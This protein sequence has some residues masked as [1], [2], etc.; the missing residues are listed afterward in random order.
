M[1]A[2]LVKEFYPQFEVT[3]VESDEIGILGAGEGTV[4]HIVAVLDFLRIP[5]SALVRE[6]SATLKT[7]IRFTNWHGDGTSYFHSFTGD[8]ELEMWS[9]DHIFRVNLLPTVLIGKA[10][11]LDSASFVA[12]IAQQGRVPFILGD[13][14]AEQRKNFPDPLN[15]LHHIGSFALHFDARLLAKYLG[16]LAQYER[17]I[18]R[19]QGKL[20]KVLSNADGSIAGL[21]L[22]D[23]TSLACDFIFDCSGFARLLLGKHFNETWVDYSSYLPLDTALP[24]FLPHDGTKLPPY[25]EAIAMKYGWIWKIPVQDRYGCGYVFDS[26]FINEAQALAEVEDWLGHP[27]T[28]PKTF[29]FRAGAFHNSLVKN[30]F[31]VGLAQNFVEP[32]EA[33]SIWVFTK[34]LINLLKSDVLNRLD[35][36]VA[37]RVNAS[38][39]L[40]NDPIPEFLQLHYLTRRDDS[41]F[42]QTFRQRMTIMPSLQAK[43]ELWQSLPVFDSDSVQLDMFKAPS[44]ITVGAGVDIFNREVFLQFARNFEFERNIDEGYQLL[45]RKQQRVAKSCMSHAD[46]LALLKGH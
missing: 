1:T 14:P 41:P 27:V 11:P 34:N 5:V 13:I 4:P 38:C 19:A 9:L 6:C 43:L 18:K 29:K 17:G 44:W 3:L 7:G 35:D 24:F 37:A 16:K 28:S 12:K 36:E 20:D 40:V 2:L 23:G 30:C 15:T 26:S 8:A 42:W 25:T 31:A 45:L 10:M 33:T 32:L 22:D 46:F 39:R 21:L